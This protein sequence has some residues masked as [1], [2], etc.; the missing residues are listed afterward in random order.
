MSLTTAAIAVTRTSSRCCP[1]VL[2]VFEKV[3]ATDFVE[4]LGRQ[5]RGS[6]MV[7]AQ[8]DD[9][10][11]KVARMTRAHI[12]LAADVVILVQMPDNR[13]IERQVVTP[14]VHL[15]DPRELIERRVLRKNLVR[16]TTEKRLVGERTRLEVRCED[17]HH[18]ER[19]LEFPS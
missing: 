16:D 14:A 9:L 6:P 10:V 11:G 19:H 1:H 15:E 17:D 3:R 13:L 8:T 18:V 4:Q 5:L 7:P 2:R 12:E